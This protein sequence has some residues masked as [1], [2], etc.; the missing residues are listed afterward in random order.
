MQQKCS[1]GKA[2]GTYTRDGSTQKCPLFSLLCNTFRAKRH[3]FPP[4]YT[5]KRVQQCRQGSTHNV[6]RNLVLTVVVA[7]GARGG[8]AVL[9]D[10]TGGD[11]HKHMVQVLQFGRG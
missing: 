5:F 3:T 8:D 10:G 7:V 1:G 4:H 11:G 2:W 9:D 6:E